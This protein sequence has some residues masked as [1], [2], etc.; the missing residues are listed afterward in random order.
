MEQR[1]L[2]AMDGLK[3]ESHEMLAREIRGAVPGKGAPDAA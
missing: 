3:A 2:E 1:V